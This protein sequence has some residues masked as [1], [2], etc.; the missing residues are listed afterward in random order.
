ME[1][2][3]CIYDDGD[4]S[5][6][7]NISIRTNEIYKVV[8]CFIENGQ[9]YIKIIN[10]VNNIVIYATFRFEDY[11]QEVRDKKLNDLFNI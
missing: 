10:R 11:T 3:K 8:D 5:S 4:V 1:W 2:V 6:I 7:D 9:E